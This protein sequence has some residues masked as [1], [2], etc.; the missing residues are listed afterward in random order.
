MDTNISNYVLQTIN[1]CSHTELSTFQLAELR[2]IA[3]TMSIP[4]YNKRKDALIEEIARNLSNIILR[5]GNFFL[6]VR[7]DLPIIN[8]EVEYIAKHPGFR[9]VIDKYNELTATNS[10]FAYGQFPQANSSKPLYKCV[11]ILETYNEKS[12][13]VSKRAITAQSGH[14]QQPRKKYGTL[15][16]I[17]GLPIY[18]DSEDPLV[19]CVNTDCGRY[20]HAYCMRIKSV[21]S[22]ETRIFECPNC[23]LKR[24][25]PLHEIL[26]VLH[27][28][29]CLDNNKQEFILDQSSYR[30]MESDRSVGVEVRCM[31]IEE[32][33]HEQ[34]WPHQ[35]ELLIDNKKFLEFKPLQ[36]NSSLKKRKDEKLFTR[37]I[38]SGLHS[39]Q[40]KYYPKSD[41]QKENTGETYYAAIYLV[42]KL[43]CEELIDQIKANNVQPIEKCKANVKDQ[44]SKR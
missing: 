32:K 17:C 2:K 30:K 15:N 36:Q 10:P 25:D 1:R 19:K 42:R 21:S 43:T 22:E 7:G 12:P 37:E 20:L 18:T 14:K 44:F 11:N 29:F 35:G 3:G 13:N 5:S 4:T 38:T 40:I 26:S 27:A 9:K 24:C 23:A 6:H 33:T 8:P 34:T 39:F 16:C 31:R 28:P 41:F